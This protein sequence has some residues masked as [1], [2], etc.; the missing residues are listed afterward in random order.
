[1]TTETVFPARAS[2]S[3]LAAAASLC[4]GVCVFSIQDVI[5]K[6]ISG[7]Y[8]LSEAVALRAVTSLPILLVM[9]HLRSGL[10]SLVSRRLGRHFLRG[11]I[12]MSAYGA[13]YLALPA[14]KLAEAVTLY[15]TAPLFITAL[16]YPMLGERVGLNRWLAVIVGFL[17]VVVTYR[18]GLGLFDWASLLPVAAAFA[19]GTAQIM[20]RQIGATESAAVIAFH[21]NLAYLIGALLLAA[22]FGSGA[23]AYPNMHPSMAFLLRPWSFAH[24]L[25]LLLLACCGLIAAIGSVL[26]SQAYR[27]AEANFVA[28]FEY[29]GL[30]WATGWGFFVFGEVPD[31]YIIAG[32][33]LIIGAGLY[34]L[35]ARDRSVA[36]NDPPGM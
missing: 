8:P 33:A 23:F 24:P 20:A 11:G 2:G 5:L 16:A 7:T 21:Q 6:W 17:G 3:R 30:I 15:F 34:M 31:I 29:S 4:A 36:R 10:G 13:Y 28:S 9:V 18:P 1:M 22:V 25:D 12:M 26:L 27:T 35:M 32:A 14:M 19:Y